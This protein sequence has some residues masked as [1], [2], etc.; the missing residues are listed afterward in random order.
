[1]KNTTLQ[2]IKAV[3]A[4]AKTS[5]DVLVDV[6]PPIEIPVRGWGSSKASFFRFVRWSL[7]SKEITLC[8][9]GGD[10]EDYFKLSLTGF[11][12]IIINWGHQV[13]PTPIDLE[14]LPEEFCAR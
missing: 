8:P 9:R 2:K 4:A 11:E 1:M 13:S 7:Q 14:F 6:Y 5:T 10:H 3:N 12:K